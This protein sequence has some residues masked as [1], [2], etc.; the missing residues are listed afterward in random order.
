MTIT[1]KYSCNLCNLHRV[2]LEVTAREAEDL[3][4]W[5]DNLTHVISRD[6]QYRSP[7]CPAKKITELM[8]P[9]PIGTDKVGGPQT[10]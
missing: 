9:M 6:H 5:M 4:D 1:I 8:I 2:S 10:Q 7:G 3:M